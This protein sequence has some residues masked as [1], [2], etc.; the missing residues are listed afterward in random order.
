MYGI[1]KCNMTGET[2]EF[3]CFDGSC[4]DGIYESFGLCAAKGDELPAANLPGVVR[5]MMVEQKQKK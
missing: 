3:A 2:C 4:K 1:C 5:R